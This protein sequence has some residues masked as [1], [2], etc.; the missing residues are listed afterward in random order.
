MKI[1]LEINNITQSPIEDGFFSV[2]AENTFSVAGYDFLENKKINVSL[3]LASPEEIKN[4]NR[5]YRQYDSVTDILSFPEYENAEE[6]KKASI[7]NYEEEL[8]LGEL[9]LCYNDIKEYAEK[10]S[11][12][13]EKELAKVVSHGILHLLGFS[14][15]EKMFMIQEDVSEKIKI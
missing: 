5:E 2:V 6:I 3:A 4:L 8:F 1:N 10:E 14:H 15:G 9:I 13:L 12:I 7:K 11:I